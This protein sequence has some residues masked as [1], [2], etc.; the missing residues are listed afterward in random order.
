MPKWYDVQVLCQFSIAGH[1]LRPLFRDLRD[2][3]TCERVYILIW[4]DKG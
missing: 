4:F 3:R 2:E 1:T